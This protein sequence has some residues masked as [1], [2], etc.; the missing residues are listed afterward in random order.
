MKKKSLDEAEGPLQHFK[1]NLDDIGARLKYLQQYVAAKEEE[2]GIK[3]EWKHLASVMDRMF[4][5]ICLF[6]SI[7]ADHH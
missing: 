4:F 2:D 5:W 7:V 3:E 6:V 1:H